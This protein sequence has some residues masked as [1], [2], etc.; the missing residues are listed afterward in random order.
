MQDD[1]I[2]IKKYKAEVVTKWVDGEPQKEEM[3][4][5]VSIASIG[6]SLFSPRNMSEPQYE[7][8]FVSDEISRANMVCSGMGTIVYNPARY[9]VFKILGEVEE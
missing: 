5:Y 3:T 8:E 9:S 7:Y 2:K 4:G 6:L 1:G